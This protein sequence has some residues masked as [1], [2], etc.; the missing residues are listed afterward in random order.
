MSEVVKLFVTYC[1]IQILWIV[2]SS[3]WLAKR[4]DE[5]PLLANLFLFYVFSFRFWALLQGWVNPVNLSNF[6]FDNVTF[7]SATEAQGLAVLGQSIFTLTYF[8]TQNRTIY[9]P[10]WIDLGT[11][12]NRIW[13][14]TLLLMLGCAPLAILARKSALAQADAGKSLAFEISSYLSLFPLA[15][16]GIA[17]L[18]GALWRSGA[19]EDFFSRCF[20][21]LSLMAIAFITFQSSLRFQFV[22]W[23]SAVAI[24]VASGKSV[25]KKGWLL[26]GGLALAAVAFSIAGALRSSADP[27]S[28]LGENAWDRFVFAHDANML[29]GFVLLRQVYPDMLNYSYGGEH[30][31][32]FERP[33]PRLW[34]PGK[35]VGGYMN[36]LGIVDVNTGFTLG[37][38]P[39]LFGSFYQ[40][41]AVYGVILL[42]AIYGYGFG[43]LIRW[44]AGLF[45]LTSLLI[46]GT[47]C[48]AIVPLL[49]GGDL[50]G[51]YAWFGMSF[52]PVA[53]VMLLNRRQLFQRELA[54]TPL[55][56]Q[57]LHPRATV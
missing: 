49:R 1:V 24:I 23:V 37:I 52:W 25:G 4:K 13:P 36:K 48:A 29:D 12:G 28:D 10:R 16:V 30:L 38:S 15:L 44:S 35:P 56:P 19:L 41:G 57:P 9:V 39:S 55:M 45:P 34:W 17:I 2:A 5:I 26:G 46:R 7:D 54:A 42:S 43:R 21:V 32:I 3:I 33:I 20:A 6:G 40:E 18:L 27:E 47:L 31:E 14:V 8:W 53:L 50:P 11:I 51:I 22:G